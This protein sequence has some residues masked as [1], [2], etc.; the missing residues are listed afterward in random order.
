MRAAVV[1]RAWRTLEGRPVPPQAIQWLARRL[2]A[3]GPSSLP[4]DLI[5]QV[6]RLR[7]QRTMHYVNSRSPF[8]RELLRRHGVRPADIRDLADLARLPCTTSDDLRDWRRFQCVPDEG[9]RA[10]FTTS[11]STGQPK[12]ITFTGRDLHTLANW[13][14]FSLRIG[15]PGRLWA[16]IALP[17]EHGLWIG[18]ASAARAVERAGGLPLPVGAGD[19]AR[20]LD[21]LRR[22]EPDLVISSPSYMTALTR[23]AER[24]ACRPRLSQILL[25]GEMLSADQKRYF[26]QVWGA[27]VLDAYGTTEMGGAQAIALPGC[28]AFSL[29]DL[30]LAVEIVDPRSGAPAN[31]GELVFTTLARQ[32]MPLVRYRSGDRARWAGCPCGL[33]LHSMQILGRLDDMLVAGDMNLHGQAIADQVAGLPGATGRVELALDKVALTDRLRLR[34]EGH[35]LEAPAIQRALAEAYPELPD[36]LRHGLLILEIET[37]ADLGGQLKPFK[38]VD[39]RAPRPPDQAQA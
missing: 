7:L 37:G 2:E 5:R 12:R 17:V 3:R 33:P 26:S 18:A 31:E 38:I 8:Y 4:P 32:A 9:I 1:E 21:W 6:Q 34:V 25:S 10:V 13:A 28:L 27:L 24:K 14:A 39:R 11:G 16:L 19:P 20:A 15:H 35:G 22:F 29:N 36:R 30:G 23:E